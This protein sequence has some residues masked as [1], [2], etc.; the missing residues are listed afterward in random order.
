MTIFCPKGH[1]NPDHNQFCQA[2]GTRI[3]HPTASVETVVQPIT[4]QIVNPIVNPMTASTMLGDRYRIKN[5]IGQGGFGRTFLCEDVNRFN[6]LCVLKEF[7]PQVQGT[8]FLIKAE[9]L[10]E[11]EAGVMYRLQH[12][13]IPRFRE[14]FRS[15][16]N[17]V[18]QLFLVQDYVGGENYQQLLRQKLQQGQRFSELEITEF[19]TQI[20]PVLGYIHSL[21]VIHRDISPDNLIKRTMDGLPVLIDFGGVKQVAVNAATQYMPSNQPNHHIAT[22]L[23]K[24][25][26]APSEQMQRGVVSPQSDLYALAA[27]S[28]VLLT[29]LEPPDLIDP[30]N[31]IWNW[32][33]HVRLSPHFASVLDRMLQLRPSDRFATAQD[34][35]DAISSKTFNNFAPTVPKPAPATILPP[36]AVVQPP[37]MPTA[38]VPTVVATPQYQSPQPPEYNP[39]RAEPGLLDVLGKT[40]M[41]IFSVVGALGLGWGIASLIGSQSPKQA[42]DPTEPPINQTVTP[43]PTPTP[44][45]TISPSISPSPT[46]ISALKV[47]IPAA[48]ASRGINPLAYENAVKQIFTAQN[49]TIQVI[50]AGDTAIQSQLDTISSKLG[51]KLNDYLTGDAIGKIGTYTVA[52]RAT[53]RSQVNKLNLSERALMDLTDARYRAITEL[54]AKKLDLGYDR[55]LGTAMGQIYLATMSD[56]VRAIQDKKA[57]GEIVFPVGGTSGIVKGTLQPGEGKAF[58]SSL[59]GGQEIGIKLTASQSSKLSIYPPNSKLP[60]MLESTQTNN[61]S[62]KTTV[63]GL[64]EFVFVSNS[65]LPIQYELTLTATQVNPVKSP[66]TPISIP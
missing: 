4:N 46:S 44:T 3:M 57:T 31:F 22:R 8:A 12:P 66:P 35:L 18:G 51:S 37:Q 38:P 60:A 29:G 25:G 47:V 40:W 62:G 54:S 2:C 27:T 33:E 58:L 21:G 9:E 64:H 28:L 65:D 15:N 39:P 42:F 6:E 41:I 24:V 53:W 52:D 50:P 11:R 10:F 19:L 61:W 48:L 1:E 13:Q 59:A 34:V 30:Q 63:N 16:R 5:E 23:G 45:P 14:M 17:G 36:T 7:A 56:R 49:P 43:T 55:F 20:L 26:Y 32:R